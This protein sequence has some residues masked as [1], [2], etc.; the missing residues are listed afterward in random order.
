MSAV[1]DRLMEKV[2]WNGDEHEC[3]EWQGGCDRVRDLTRGY[4]RFWLNGRMESAH[5]VAYEEFIG[6]V[7]EGQFV[8]HDCDNP[9]CVNPVH[10][11]AGTNSDN[12]ADR[13][14]RGRFVSPNESKTHCAKGHPYDADNTITRRIRRNGKTYAYRYC[15][16]CQGRRR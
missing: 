10:L 5:R 3:W 14:R 16:A 8:L 1:L 13:V 9:P 7:P 4:G 11:Y 2:V 6:P 15:R 12:Q